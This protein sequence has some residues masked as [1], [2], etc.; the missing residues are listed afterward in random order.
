MGRL[1]AFGDNMAMAAG[2][3]IMNTGD[4]DACDVAAVTAHIS[5]VAARISLHK[6]CTGQVSW[7]T[8]YNKMKGQGLFKNNKICNKQRRSREVKGAV[9]VEADWF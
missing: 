3:T 7:Q 8:I 4:D 5:V 9:Q 2:A 1:L 6:S